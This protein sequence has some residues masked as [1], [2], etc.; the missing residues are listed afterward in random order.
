MIK[1]WSMIKRYVWG[2]SL[3]FQSYFPLIIIFLF[4]FINV[5]DEKLFFIINF[6]IFYDNF[7]S[8]GMAFLLLLNAV[9]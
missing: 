3:I 1:N 4:V 7:V 6:F 8:F 9:F 2:S 5:Y